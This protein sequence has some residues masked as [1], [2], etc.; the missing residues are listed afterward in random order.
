MTDCNIVSALYQSAQ[1]QGED[2]ALTALEEGHWRQWSFEQIAEASRG[3]AGALYMRGVRRGDRVMLMVRPSMEFV[4]LTFGL[5]QLG[6]VIILIDPGMGYKNL[7]RCIGS[8]K[9]DILVG[10]SKAILFSRFFPGPFGSVRKRILVGK[11]GLFVRNPLQPVIHPELPAFIATNED[12]AAIIFTT[13]STGP[14]KGVEYTHGIFHTQ[15]RL[16]RD[17]FGIGAG[18]IDQPGFPLFGLFATALGAQ[19]VIP[20]MDPT[21]PAQVDPEKFVATIQA[22]KVTYSFGSPAIWNVVSRYCLEKGI[23]LPVRKVLMAGAPVP[24][25][26]VERVQKILPAEGQIYTPYG[27]TESLPVA[28]I[29]GR[30]IVESTWSQT[31]IGRGACVGRSLPEMK[32][33]IIEPVDG[34]IENWGIVKECAAGQIGEIVVRGPVVTRAYA[35]NEKE[36]LSAKI[37]DSQGFWHRMGDMGYLDQEGRLWFCGRKAHRVSTDK[38]MLYTICCEAIFNEHPLVRRSALV[39][40]GNWGNQT[41]VLVVELFKK[42]KD[43]EKLFKELRELALANPLTV[44]IDRF[45]IHSSFPVDIRHNA[46]IFREKLADWAGKRVQLPCG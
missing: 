24:G 13:G 3:Y 29:E 18:D 2:I 25:E 26:L 46:K 38:G 1:K 4:C 34:V 20:D 43:E 23:V 9:P 17:Y 6:A 11:G 14:P 45:L 12:L 36:T 27:A 33:T 16:I 10:I 15:L 41:P 42:T 40:L 31:R 28:A 37:P 35:G 7:L 32:L 30:E 39:G 19:A 5:F 21:R 22:H 8:V 44:D